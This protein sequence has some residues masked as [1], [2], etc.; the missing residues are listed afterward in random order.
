[1]AD[2]LCPGDVNRRITVNS[3]SRDIIRMSARPHASSHKDGKCRVRGNPVKL[4]GIT[5]LSIY[6]QRYNNIAGAHLSRNGNIKTNVA[7]YK[8]DTGSTL[9]SGTFSNIVVS[10]KQADG[11]YIYKNN[12]LLAHNSAVSGTVDVGNLCIGNT[13]FGYSSTFR[14]CISDVK[15][16]DNYLDYD[17][18]N[19][20]V[21]AGQLKNYPICMF[22]NS[23]GDYVIDVSPTPVEMNKGLFYGFPDYKEDS[24]FS[25]T[26]QLFMK[27]GEAYNCYITAWDDA[28]HSS[29]LN[30]VL[31]EE[32]CKIT[33]CVYRSPDANID[34]WP[35]ANQQD[36][37][38]PRV[39]DYVSDFPIKGNELYY[40]KFNLV[41]YVREP[42][43]VGD[44][45]SIR[46]RIST[47]NSD[48]FIPGNYDFILSLHYQ[49]T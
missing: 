7:E 6:I 47:I 19:E 4:H 20:I 45:V 17:S 12:N 35:D 34:T 15:Y 16:W 36:T 37:T 33:A 24:H 13:S 2:N 5:Y 38:I 49:Y 21:P 41:Y 22:G 42:N 29:V 3:C 18:V 32:L 9:S 30:T 27:L 43:I 26:I 44:I 23:V 14:G 40:G 46:P 25:D 11:L 48:I 31:K 10:Y 39:Y 1:L 28:T 8:S